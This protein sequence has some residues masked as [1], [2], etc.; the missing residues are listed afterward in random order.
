MEIVVA[1]QTCNRIEFTKQVIES[2]L[3]HNP[4]AKEFPWVIYDDNSAD[5]TIN[6]LHSLPFITSLIQSDKRQGITN[7]LKTLFTESYNYGEIALYI[8]NDWEQIRTIDFEAIKVFFSQYLHAGHLQTIKF[9]GPNNSRPSSTE[10]MLNLHNKEKITPGTPIKIGNETIIPGNWHYCDLPGFSKL[11][12]A[13]D[14]FTDVLD[15]S[16]RIKHFFDYPCDNY[17]LENQPYENIDANGKH[18]T[19]KRKL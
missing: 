11:A 16:V 1:I 2:I 7:G 6:Y 12:I 17:L 8:Q 3:K 4:E 9:K 14:M 13:K 10:K 18:R 5:G 15:E 19:P